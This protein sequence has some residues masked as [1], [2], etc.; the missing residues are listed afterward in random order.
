MLEMVDDFMFY[1]YKVH[2][3]NNSNYKEKDSGKVVLYTTSMGIIRDTYA[4]CSNV[5]Q[6]LRTL[7]VK[8]E[9]RDV[10]MSLEYQQEIKE[11]MHSDII[12]VPQLFV[13]GQHIG[14]LHTC[15]ARLL[16]K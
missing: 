8:F 9:E 15:S 2:I 4:K 12:K 16:A 6:I 7:L 14:E 5:K 11:R 13:E 1:S 10:F 3:Y